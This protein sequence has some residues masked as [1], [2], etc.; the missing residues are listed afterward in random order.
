MRDDGYTPW[1]GPRE[2]HP[3]FYQVLI[4]IF[5][6]SKG[7]VAD[8]TVVTSLKKFVFDLKLFLTYFLQTKMLSFV[9]LLITVYYLFDRA[10]YTCLPRFETSPL[11]IGR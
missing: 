1:R 8:L 11:G 9:V 5:S 4:N 7:I 10:L 2:R 3:L 6:K